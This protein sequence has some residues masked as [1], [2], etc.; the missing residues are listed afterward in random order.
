MSDWA[1]SIRSVASRGAAVALLALC[2]WVVGAMIA[3]PAIERYR[4]LG[5]DIQ[6]IRMQ[7]GR[8][9][10][11]LSSS[12][13]T[14]T[15]GDSSGQ[16]WRGQ[17]RSIVAAKVQEF[18]QA[19]ARHHGVNVI[20]ISPL[21]RRP[22]EHFEAIGL[23]IE[24]EGEIGAIRDLIGAME[25]AQPFLFITGTDLR[26]QQIFGARRPDQKLPLAARLDVYAPFVQE[27]GK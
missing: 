23:R 9:E 2:L 10:A 8:I 4:Q 1:L 16:S 21:Q 11:I 14:P 26:R 18:L 12:P 7:M 17:G 24:C 13:A 5:S 20:S 6:D 19:Q 25:S 27:D 22:F 3:W 15:A